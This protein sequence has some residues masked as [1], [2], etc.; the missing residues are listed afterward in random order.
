MITPSHRLQRLPEGVFQDLAIAK[1]QRLAAGDDVIDLSVGSPDFAPPVH[2][3][4]ELAKYAADPSQYG[5]AITALPA[6][7]QAVAEFYQRY[8]V[9]LDP[10]REVL[11]LAGSQEGLSHLA[12][13]FINPGDLVLI[14]DP[15][16]PIY[17]A[18][19]RLAGGDIMAI[20]VDPVTLH[21][22]LDDLSVQD[23]QRA[24]LM[25]LNYPSNPTAG[26][27]TRAM[28][29]H[30][31]R[32]AQEY[33]IFIV[34][35]FAYSELI[36]DGNEAI[37]ILS[38]PGA[39]DV[40]IEFNSL[41]KTYNLAGARI[42]YAVGNPTA[43]D[44]L[45]KLKSHMDFGVFLPIQRAAI[46]ALHE[47]WDGYERQRIAYAKRRDAFCHALADMGWEVRK[48][49]AT[50]FVWAKTPDDEQSY[51]FALDL[52]RATG[53]G[54]TPGIAFGPH[55]EG[56]VRMAFVH[57]TDVLLEAARRIGE[58]LKRR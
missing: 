14:P 1:G 42:A 30:V 9:S 43:L 35:D 47:P 21:P 5:Y 22:R 34:H 38:I 26:L 4:A 18:G 56:Y 17:E 6:F 16:Y 53:V 41:S 12:L 31:V 33:D 54:V 39:K 24:K 29:E 45:R 46:T 25:I 20:P 57:E 58:W 36:Y 13:T 28:F 32:L 50:M 49:A 15:G 7:Q 37:S 8:D 10:Q 51:P 3:M 48:P 44:C 11:Q 23:L 19:V 40:A 27:A 2:A 52:L 55:G